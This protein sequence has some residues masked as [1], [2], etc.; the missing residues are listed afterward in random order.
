MKRIALIAAAA[1]ALL[2]MLILGLSGC[3]YSEDE[4]AEAFRQ[5]HRAG[6]IWCKREE[7]VV[8]P[9]LPAALLAEWQRGWEEGTRL[10]C[11]EKAAASR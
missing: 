3:G 5:G 7:P 10:Q 6:I 11:P 8:H 4:L 1:T 9:D 2:A